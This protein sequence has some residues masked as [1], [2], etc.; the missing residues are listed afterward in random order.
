MKTKFSTTW[1]SS[2]QPR[3]QRK[4][5]KN[6]PLHIKRKVTLSAHLTKSLRGQYGKRSMV[7]RVG[8]KVRV[9]VGGFKGK[10]GVVDVINVSTGKVQI[11]GIEI[12]KKDG[13]KMMKTIPASNLEIIDL[14]LDDS[15]RRN[16]IERSKPKEE[17]ANS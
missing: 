13:T 10:T 6:A 11:R 12:V 3:K 7:V 1:K 16:I 17:K 15:K 14:N 8:D 4:F 2:K 5:A 9:L